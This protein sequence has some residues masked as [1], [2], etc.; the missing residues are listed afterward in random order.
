VVGPQSAETS[1]VPEED[2]WRAQAYA[3]LSRLLASPPT[4]GDL[5]RLTGFGG[6]DSP[7]GRALALLAERA[8]HTSAA[9]ADAEFNRLFIGLTEGELR[10][11]AS[12][13]LTGFLYEKPLAELRADLEVLGVTRASDVAEPEDHIAQLCEVMHGLISGTFG[14]PASLAD[15]RRFFSR[16]IAPW[17]G[18]FFA[19]LETARQ[20]DL[21]RPVGRI[22][23]LFVTIE[24]EAFAMVG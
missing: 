4:E 9:A 11:Y 8:L 1:G 3:L 20:A 19:D 16:H 5:R 2:W 23:R 15:Q 17:A 18:T 13:Y 24:D 7:L 12:C 6:D 22:G 10:P 14:A 21:Y